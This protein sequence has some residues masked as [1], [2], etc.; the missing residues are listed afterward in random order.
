MTH[1]S[2]LLSLA[3]NAV[4]RSADWPLLGRC[5]SLLVVTGRQLSRAVFLGWTALEPIYRHAYG[6]WLWGDPIPVKCTASE[7]G[8][9]L[10]YDLANAPYCAR[11]L[12]GE[13]TG[14]SQA[15]RWPDLVG[16]LFPACDRFIESTPLPRS[17]APEAW[18][19]SWERLNR[20]IRTEAGVRRAYR[21]VCDQARP[22][23]PR[24]SERVL[25][26]SQPLPWPRLGSFARG[27]T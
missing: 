11:V 23:L 12:A 18:P 14:D 22:L 24:L 20:E 16:G 25:E 8:R 26:A 2:P 7:V 21:Q 17:Y 13:P 10:L 9:S 5:P 27:A 19:T 3:R 15:V 1:R 4:V 6:R